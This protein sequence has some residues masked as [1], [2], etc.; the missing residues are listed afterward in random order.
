MI[1]SERSF[2]L[3]SR[4]NEWK[5]GAYAYALL[6]SELRGMTYTPDRITLKGIQKSLVRAFTYS[7][8]DGKTVILLLSRNPEKYLSFMV[9][10]LEDVEI[11]TKGDVLG[12]PADRGLGPIL[13][14][15]YG[16]GNFNIHVA[17][18]PNP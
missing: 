5:P 2:G 12:T 17:L 15:G 10:G 14:K 6:A 18:R 4:K 16:S 7:G 11:I 13:I 1:P 3:M 9:D 8:T